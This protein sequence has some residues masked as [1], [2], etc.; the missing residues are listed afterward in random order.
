MGEALEVYA[1]KQNR[2]K[3][4]GLNVLADEMR[5][6]FKSPRKK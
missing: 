5:T 3:I 1:V 4:A 6:F 2:D